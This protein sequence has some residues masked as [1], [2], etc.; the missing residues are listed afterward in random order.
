[1]YSDDHGATWHFAPN[2]LVGAGTTE[3][4]VVQ[5]QHAPNT[6]MFN[7]RSLNVCGPPYQG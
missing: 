7:H 6:L 1:M 4:E 3:S 5:L 2:S